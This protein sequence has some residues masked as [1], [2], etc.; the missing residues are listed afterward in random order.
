MAARK[1]TTA[2]RSAS[3]STTQ[4]GKR[5]AAAATRADASK[6][7]PV[8]PRPPGTVD[9]RSEATTLDLARR[10]VNRATNTEG[11]IGAPPPG[12][13]NQAA[14]DAAVTGWILKPRK[15]SSDYCAYKL[16][17][18]LWDA[19]EMRSGRRDVHIFAAKKTPITERDFDWLDMLFVNLEALADEETEESGDSDTITN[20]IRKAM[21]R[22]VDER[23]VLARRAKA[24]GIPLLILSLKDSYS[25]PAAMHAAASRAA[26]QARRKLHRFNDQD[27]ALQLIENLEDALDDLLKLIEGDDDV[28]LDVRD[29]RARRAAL[30]RLLFDTIAYIGQWGQDITAGDPT[31]EKVYALDKIF[32]SKSGGSEEEV[33]D[34]DVVDEGDSEGTTGVT[35]STATVPTGSGN[36]ATTTSGSGRGTTTKPS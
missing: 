27:Y 13:I 6:L 24:C 32:P 21:D 25:D 7:R 8:L 31:R 4:K 23:G 3:R 11:V 19:R 1:K 35:V 29:S 18:V 5:S 30:K 34:E 9:A 16:S 26:R 12:E 14:V 28:G 20:D 2:S 17:R 33:Q 36:P 22:V 15:R 10:E